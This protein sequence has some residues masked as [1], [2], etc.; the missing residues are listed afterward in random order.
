MVRNTEEGML[1]GNGSPL[2]LGLYND[3]RYHRVGL[4]FTSPII[5]DEVIDKALSINKVEI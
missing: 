5:Y 3:G 1:V 2:F 4:Y